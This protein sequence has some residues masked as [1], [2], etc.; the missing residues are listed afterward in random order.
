MIPITLIYSQG[1]RTRQVAK[2]VHQIPK[3]GERVIPPDD[4]R[5]RNV[6]M[7]EHDFRAEDPGV[8]I[9]LS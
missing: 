7:V 6:I 3:I 1:G 8:W 2:N 4:D 5:H 9:V